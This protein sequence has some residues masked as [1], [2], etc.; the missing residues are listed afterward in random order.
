V[1]EWYQRRFLVPGKSQFHYLDLR[2]DLIEG[3]PPGTRR[4]A[5]MPWGPARCFAE[6]H[7][8]SI[9]LGP[10]ASDMVEHGFFKQ[11]DDGGKLGVEFFSEFEINDRMEEAWHGIMYFMDAERYRTPRGLTQLVKLTGVDNR[12]ALLLE[13]ERIYQQNATMWTEGIWEVVKATNSKTKFLLTDNPVT[14][15]NSRAF[16][17]SPMMSHPNDA[18]LAWVGTRTIFPLDL[19]TCLIITHREFT[20]NPWKPPMRGRINA[21][22]YSHCIFNAQQVQTGRIL[23]EDEVLRLNFILKKR[24]DRYVA[25]CDEA[26]LY[27][28]RH[29]SMSW[30]KLDDDWFMLPNLFELHLGGTILVGSKDGRSAGW[31]EYGFAREHPRFEKRERDE[32]RM[33]RRAQREWG[34]RRLLRSVGISN[35]FHHRGRNRQFWDGYVLD[36]IADHLSHEKRPGGID[37]IEKIQTWRRASAAPDT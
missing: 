7:L 5:I 10:W 35:H 14:F 27:P 1:P 33:H 23:E 26:W 28:E 4:K 8:Y 2:P 34:V 16:P 22:T 18:A 11:I 25:A 15:Y 31:D 29:T 20:R 9:R 6:D 3:A 36:E 12:N 19:D 30:S 24:A 21:R 37:T 32:D 13:L 17:G